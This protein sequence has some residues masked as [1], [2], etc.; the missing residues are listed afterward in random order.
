MAA[1]K[2]SAC[3][4]KIVNGG[5]DVINVR[6]VHLSITD[7][8]RNAGIYTARILKGEKPA[9][10]PVIQPTKFELVINLKTARALG[11]AIPPTLLATADE[12]IE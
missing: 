6:F 5:S 4:C 11:L 9:N 10:L 3:A 2:S 8:Y 1:V 7:A 12:V